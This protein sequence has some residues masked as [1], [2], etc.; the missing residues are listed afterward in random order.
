M[1]NK[2]L[3]PAEV[4]AS[5]GCRLTNQEVSVRISDFI[6]E[7]TV[8]DLPFQCSYLLLRVWNGDWLLRVEGCDCELTFFTL[9]LLEHRFISA[10][11]QI[12]FWTSFSSPVCSSSRNNMM[13]LPL[14]FYLVSFSLSKVK[15]MWAPHPF[16]LCTSFLC[17]I[18]AR[19]FERD[20][21][22]LWTL[23]KSIFNN[24]LF[25]HVLLH[26]ANRY[27]AMDLYSA[28]FFVHE[29]AKCWKHLK[30]EGPV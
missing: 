30:V 2:I 15:F 10:V 25:M 18:C 7:T 8:F 4:C 27:L 23:Q 29:C 14:F 3:Y 16:P 19:E 21:G 11:S 9:R 12:F 22:T 26:L 5:L 1:N 17:V 24:S 28:R 6:F 13:L 20:E